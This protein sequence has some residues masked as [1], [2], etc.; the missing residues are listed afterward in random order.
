MITA[1][2][3]S[4]K[5]NIIDITLMRCEIRLDKRMKQF[6][7]LNQVFRKNERINKTGGTASGYRPNQS[8][9]KAVIRFARSETRPNHNAAY[10]LN[11]R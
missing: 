8:P 6:E 5:E 9:M 1:V 2:T 3:I 10:S 4:L 11:T 7:R